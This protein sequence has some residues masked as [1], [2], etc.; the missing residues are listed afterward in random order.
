MKDQETKGRDYY[1]G[2]YEDWKGSGLP[3]G[4]FCKQASVKYATFRYWAKKFDTPANVV[5]GFTELR[6]KPANPAPVAVLDFPSGVSLSFYQL[7]DTGWLKTL[8]S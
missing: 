5:P 6:M 3:V 7:P 8:L 4:S 2:L 1:L